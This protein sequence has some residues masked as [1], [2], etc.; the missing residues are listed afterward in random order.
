MTTLDDKNFQ[1]C[2]NKCNKNINK[3]FKIYSDL[4]NGIFS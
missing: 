1:K 3:V 4:L 2:I